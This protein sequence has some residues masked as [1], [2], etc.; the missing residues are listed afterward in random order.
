MRHFQPTHLIEEAISRSNSGQS[1]LEAARK[2]TFEEREKRAIERRQQ[3]QRTAE[4]SKVQTLKV[5]VTVPTKTV[6]FGPT[7]TTSTVVAM[8]VASFVSVHGDESHDTSKTSTESA[9]SGSCGDADKRDLIPSE[10]RK[11]KS[12]ALDFER[13]SIGSNCS[14][15]IVVK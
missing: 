15:P 4:L 10:T 8:S 6:Y 9:V 2:Q 14:V 12:E 7:V 13:L 1:S 11:S 5:T 3:I